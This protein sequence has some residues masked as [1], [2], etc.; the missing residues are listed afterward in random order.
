MAAYEKSNF[1]KTETGTGYDVAYEIA[2]NS[3][4][5]DKNTFGVYSK[6]TDKYGY[7]SLVDDVVIGKLD[8]K[9]SEFL[10]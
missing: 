2:K 6:K 5:L 8:Y 3:K 4:W 7:Y 9:E 10:I 1:L